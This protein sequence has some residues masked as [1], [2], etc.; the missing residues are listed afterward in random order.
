MSTI[1]DQAPALSIII[2]LL[3]TI[4][5]ISTSVVGVAMIGGGS[6]QAWM[7]TVLLA[8]WAVAYCILVRALHRYHTQ[9]CSAD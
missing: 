4:L 6:S 8:E 3:F 1:N 9:H 7:I 5:T 2:L